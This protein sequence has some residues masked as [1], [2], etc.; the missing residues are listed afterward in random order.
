[1]SKELC[2][3]LCRQE[4]LHTDTQTDGWL[5]TRVASRIDPDPQKLRQ[6]ADLLGID[7]DTYFTIQQQAADTGQGLALEVS[8]LLFD[9]SNKKNC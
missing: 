9:I 2:E 5:L 3:E 4:I 1:M 6:F 8:S 7:D